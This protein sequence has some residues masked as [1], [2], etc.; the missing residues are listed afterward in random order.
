M[1]EGAKKGLPGG[2]PDG[3]LL[4]AERN[5]AIIRIVKAQ[6]SYPIGLLKKEGR[7][8]CSKIQHKI[9]L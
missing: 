8:S 4:T 6:F 2:R 1:L 3:Q 7:L 9:Q 5:T